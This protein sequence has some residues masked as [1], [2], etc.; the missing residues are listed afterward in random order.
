MARP[1]YRDAE[2]SGLFETIKV[3]TCSGQPL[4]VTTISGESTYVKPATT[5]GDSF[6]RFR[7]SEPFTL[8]DSSHR[9]TDNGKWA[10]SGSTAT[11]N[12]DEGLVDLTINTTS[13]SKVYRETTKVFPYQPGKSLQVMNS[14]V[15]NSGKANLRQRVG[16]FGADNGYYVEV[17]GTSAPFL[18]QRSSNTGS[19]VNTRV[20]QADWN[21]DKLDGKG[22]SAYT[23]D[24]TKSQLSWFD[25]EWLG[26]GTVRAGFLIDG[27]LV[28]CHSFHHAN[29]ITSTYMTTAILPCR[30]EIENLDTTA[31]DSTLK[32]ICSTVLSEGGYD[33]RGKGRATGQDVGTVYDLTNSGTL[34]PTAAIR[35]KSS[36]PDAVAVL[37]GI[38]ILGVTNNA[39][40]RWELL[41]GATTVSGG[42]WVSAGDD[43]P[44]EFNIT[45]TG[46]SGGQSLVHGFSIGS[47]QGAS[48]TD[49]STVDL[50]KY[51][52]E[53]NSFTGTSNVLAL[54]VSTQSAGADVLTALNWEEVN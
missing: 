35:L 12:A 49:L 43:S 6:G 28:H 46:I 8:F 17:S 7:V 38:S 22:P 16:Y 42:T 40:Y 18:V 36:T 14:F 53:R 47:N 13:G 23:L 27:E 50:F 51:Q 32:Q 29:A 20:A 9:Y 2:N 54:V 1:L 34:Y 26:V 4:E 41:N 45:A 52:L 25:F 24:M 5:A 11:F 31:T 37:N 39:H 33:L 48:V 10:T 21:I 30:Y 44:V 19:V 3:Q 15:M